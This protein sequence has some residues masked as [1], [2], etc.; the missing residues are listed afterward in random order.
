MIVFGFDSMQRSINAAALSASQ[1]AID[2]N[3]HEN[4]IGHIVHHTS[5][6]S[7]NPSHRDLASHWH[8]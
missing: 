3:G 7:G 6:S 1:L 2:Q 5:K 4:A 8:I